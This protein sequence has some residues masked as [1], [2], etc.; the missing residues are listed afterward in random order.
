MTKY[1]LSVLSLCATYLVQAQES[2]SSFMQELHKH[3]GKAYKGK[4]VSSPVPKDFENK[5]LIMYVMQC[6]DDQVKIP[7]FVGEDLSRTWVFTQNGNQIELKHDHR[8]NDGTPDQ[9]TMYG[10]TTSNSGSSNV[11]YFPADQFTA[12]MISG[13]AANLWWVTIDDQVFSYNLK[14]V[15]SPN[16]F[17]VVF[18]L[19]KPIE[20]DKRPW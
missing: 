6:T 20:T 2:T 13:A 12:D 5:E 14:R 15:T 10:G 7:F 18:D 17:N 4:I 8:K 19:S 11:Q 16:E 1:L 3:C 9:V